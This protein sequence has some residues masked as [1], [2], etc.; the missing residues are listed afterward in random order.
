MNKNQ[1]KI[2]SKFLFK[3]FEIEIEEQIDNLLDAYT[4][5][6]SKINR[7]ELL[8]KVNS[9]LEIFL[10]QETNETDFIDDI[11]DFL[12]D[13]S[14]VLQEK[15]EKLIAGD[16]DKKCFVRALSRIFALL[17]NTKVDTP[18]KIKRIIKIVIDY[19]KNNTC[20]KKI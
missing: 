16:S 5:S 13:L 2:A 1:P 18:E 6:S 3:M 12:K 15:F 8:E 11:F 17:L 4:T 9:E 7:T 14:D 19:D 10:S 20:K